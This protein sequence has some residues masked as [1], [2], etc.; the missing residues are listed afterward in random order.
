MWN[1]K[2]SISLGNRYKKTTAELIPIVKAAGFDGVSPEWEKDVD[3]SPVIEAAKK[4]NMTLVSLHA[5]YYGA[6]D[7][8]SEDEAV[9]DAALSD[10]LSSLDDAHKYGFPVLVCHVWIGFGEEPAPIE[11]GLYRLDRLAARAEEYGV[12]L[13]FENTEG[14]AHLNAVLTHFQGNDTVGYCWDS[15]HEMCYNRSRDLLALYGDRLLITHLNDNLGISRFDGDIFWTDDLHLLPYDGIADWDFNIARL[16]KSRPLEYLNFEL[17]MVSKP[18]RHEND[19]YG[20][21]P[22]EE[23]FALAYA[24]ACRIAHRYVN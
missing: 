13:A 3:L 22:E 15:G 11:V 20:K 16:K 6:A 4:E 21:M 1:Q 2:I 9:G 8:W 18:K 17:S 24:R 23:Y 10:L 19:A 12:R 5:P 7:V 14:D